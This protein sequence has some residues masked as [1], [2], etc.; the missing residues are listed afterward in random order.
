[1][2]EDAQYQEQARR[3]T[4]ERLAA[5]EAENSSSDRH[6]DPLNPH[7]GAWSAPGPLAEPQF[8]PNANASDN[9]PSSSGAESADAIDTQSNEIEQ[10]FGHLEI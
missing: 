6:F 10:R 4:A 9:S 3:I 8:A 7:F 2:I 5:E 1:M